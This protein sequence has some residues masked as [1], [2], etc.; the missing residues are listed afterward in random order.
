MRVAVL[1]ACTQSRRSSF[2]CRFVSMG[3]PCGWWASILFSAHVPKMQQVS[4]P[5]LFMQGSDDGFTAPE[6]LRSV[7]KGCAGDVNEIVIVPDK[8]HFELE[9]PRYDSFKCGLVHD[10]IMQHVLPA[11]APDLVQP[12]AE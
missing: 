9:D 11:V 12:S 5:K 1:H 10:F 6:T 3:Y 8:G 7:V 4:V 2:V